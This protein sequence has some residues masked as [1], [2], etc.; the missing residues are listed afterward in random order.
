[1][2]VDKMFNKLFTVFQILIVGERNRQGS[3]VHVPIEK[4]LMLKFV[5]GSHFAHECFKVTVSATSNAAPTMSLLFS[6]K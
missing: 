6:D 5:F 2:C 1:M 3:L 4:Q